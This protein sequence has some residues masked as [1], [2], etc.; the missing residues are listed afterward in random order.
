MYVL[1]PDCSGPL[2]A[3]P[4]ADRLERTTPTHTQHK[5]THDTMLAVHPF[6][7]ADALLFDSPRFLARKRCRLPASCT[8][9]P[10]FTESDS[11]YD[12]TLSVP[13]VRTSDISATIE[14]R[15]LRLKGETKAQ[16]RHTRFDRSIALPKDADVRSEGMK[17]VHE[18]GVLTVSVPKRELHHKQ[19]E[20]S[21]SDPAA[22]DE[23]GEASTK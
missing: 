13:G 20:I 21:T 1:R 5:R 17:L 12:V 7:L 9:E 6:S 23:A 8:S 2:D 22:V 3:R 18:D 10:S 4:D 11:A 19:L 16:H 14:E 15:T